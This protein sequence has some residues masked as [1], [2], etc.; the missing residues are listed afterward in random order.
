METSVPVAPA[1]DFGANVDTDKQELP[2]WLERR[3]HPRWNVFAAVKVLSPEFHVF[4]VD[5]LAAGGMFCPHAGPA[6]RGKRYVFELELP[7]RTSL[8]LA[9]T[10]VRSGGGFGV[11][12]R[13]DEPQAH[14]AEHLASLSGIA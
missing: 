7:D 10:V 3:E 11:G 6:C 9:G 14:I 4:Q 5:S 8:H 1:I 2:I 13:F 12:I